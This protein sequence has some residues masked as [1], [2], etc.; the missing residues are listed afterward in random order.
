[1]NIDDIKTG[2]ILKFT[3][4]GI[5]RWSSQKQTRIGLFS[6]MAWPVNAAPRKYGDWRWRVVDLLTEHPSLLRLR[7]LDTKDKKIE[8]WSTE[9]L[10]YMEEDKNYKGGVS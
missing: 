10:R 5:E 4:A 3:G 7:R 9:W 1:M 2:T 6:Q 8:V